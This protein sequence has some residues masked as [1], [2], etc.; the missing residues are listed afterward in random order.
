MTTPSTTDASQPGSV[1]ASIDRVRPTSPAEYDALHELVRLAKRVCKVPMA[2][3][4]LVSERVEFVV[5]I[6]FALEGLPLEQALRSLTHWFNVRRYP[7]KMAPE[8]RAALREEQDFFVRE[9]EKLDFA[10]AEAGPGE[11]ESVAGEW[12]HE[13]F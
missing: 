6:G 12:D 4:A 3:L 11:A 1:A 8:V 13:G 2:A 9:L 7:D 5:R 10:W